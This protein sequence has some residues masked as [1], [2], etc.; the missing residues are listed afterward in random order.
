LNVQR[1][2]DI[3]QIEIH[4]VERLVPDPNPYEA[5]TTIANLKKYKS[6]CS[7][8]IP[9]ELIQAGVETLRSEIRKHINSFW[10]KEELPDQLKDSI[11]VQVYKKANERVVIIE[12]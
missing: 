8:Q 5:E 9:S 10:S 11:I 4:T 1:A 2:S 7:D 12:K 3:R 6:P